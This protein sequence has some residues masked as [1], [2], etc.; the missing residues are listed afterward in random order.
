MKL[1]SA[2][3][4]AAAKR[5]P[6]ASRRVLFIAVLTTACSGTAFLV[7]DARRD[8]IGQELDTVR[9]L[10]A[11]LWRRANQTVE[12]FDA[13]EKSAY[14]LEGIFDNC[15][16]NWSNHVKRVE[17]LRS[18]AGPDRRIDGLLR[19]LERRRDAAEAMRGA[20][21]ADDPGRLAEARTLW[22]EL[23]RTSSGSPAGPRKGR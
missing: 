4:M 8:E 15:W 20:L 9:R 12:G 3:T 16:V 6:A 18:H 21:Q 7:H 19:Q 1:M 5:G 10:D 13:G 17:S 23:V 11:E 2:H 14:W 22:D